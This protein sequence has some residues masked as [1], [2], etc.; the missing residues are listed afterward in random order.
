MATKKKKPAVLHKSS[1]EQEKPVEHVAA[2]TEENTS[3]VIVSLLTQ[4]VTQAPAV[5]ADTKEE[6]L[7]TFSF[8]EPQPK[9]NISHLVV[10]S[11]LLILIL[12]TL[13]TFLFLSKDKVTFF[14]AKPETKPT[15]VS[16][17]STLPTPT[18]ATV[19]L[20]KYTII[21]L[22]G[23]GILGEAARAKDM[24]TAAGFTVGGIDNAQKDNYKQTVVAAKP[25]VNT[26]F[27]QKLFDIL[28]NDYTVELST[29]FVDTGAKGSD[30][31]VTLGSEK[32]T[33]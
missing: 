14:S 25:D 24:L 22:N 21:I 32:A 11:V 1:K 17:I 2:S 33:K 28:K 23:S 31:I 15:A 20:S 12:A 30:V 13:G 18:V 26:T 19:S 16:T 27:L 5:D 6:S 9:S 7:D 29:A 3:E 10:L 8:D 4:T